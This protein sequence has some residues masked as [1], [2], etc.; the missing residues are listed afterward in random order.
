MQV[1]RIPPGRRAGPPPQQVRAVPTAGGERRPP[2]EALR[3]EDAT[4]Q[5]GDPRRQPALDFV[6]PQPQSGRHSRVH[7][8]PRHGH[9]SG[10]SN[11][12][13]FCVST[14]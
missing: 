11:G 13:A 3:G 9:V 7:R 6:H 10:Q 8:G 1:Q 2:V 5:Q 14:G 12:E 4:Q